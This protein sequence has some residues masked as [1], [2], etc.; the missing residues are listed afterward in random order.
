[1]A[2]T[3]GKKKVRAKK[4]ALGLSQRRTALLT[5]SEMW[6]VTRDGKKARVPC[7]GA[8]P[9][10]LSDPPSPSRRL[11]LTAGKRCGKPARCLP[12]ESSGRDLKRLRQSGPRV[13][14]GQEYAH[15]RAVRRRELTRAENGPPVCR[16]SFSEIPPTLPSAFFFT[17]SHRVSENC[18]ASGGALKLERSRP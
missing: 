12:F 15:P 3:P 7:H 5:R 13:K 10:Q 14:H 16:H 8:L 2:E 18:V 17:S 4:Q 9:L 11:A 6:F 1:M